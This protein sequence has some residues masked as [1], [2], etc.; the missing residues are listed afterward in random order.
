[1]TNKIT[2]LCTRGIDEEYVRLA[3][4]HGIYIEI[5]PF[6]STVPIENIEVQQ[7]IEAAMLLNTTVVFTSM[8]AVESV[9][10]FLTESVQGWKIYCIGNTT[11][12]LVTKYFGDDAIAGFSHDAASLAEMI[13]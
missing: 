10:A 5:V 1:M 6:I 9:A 12:D 11:R 7:E 13:I 8:N 2:V 3:L 4:H